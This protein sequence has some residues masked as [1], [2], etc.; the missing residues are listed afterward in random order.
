MTEFVMG[1]IPQQQTKGLKHAYLEIR[2]PGHHRNLPE[3]SRK[4]GDNQLL[5]ERSCLATAVGGV[6]QGS[7]GSMKRGAS[8]PLVATTIRTACAIAP[9]QDR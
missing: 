5:T 3:T 7:A 6:K 2:H 9:R 1:G 8:A 4:V